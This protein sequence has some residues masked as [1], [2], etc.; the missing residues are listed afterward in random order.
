MPSL[1][2]NEGQPEVRTAGASSCRG[3]SVC[4]TSTARSLVIFVKRLD[5]VV[6]PIKEVLGADH[7]SQAVA[8]KV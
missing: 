2:S 1:A 7:P 4:C 3:S 6:Q 8:I 5:G